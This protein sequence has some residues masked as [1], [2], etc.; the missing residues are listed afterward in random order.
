MAGR[1]LVEWSKGQGGIGDICNRVKNFFKVGRG[2]IPTGSLDTKMII[3]EY[4][5][6]L[7]GYNSDTL[8]EIDQLLERYDLPKFTRRN[9]KS[10]KA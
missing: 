8:D 9:R 5:N 2:V 4:Y 6:Q 7:S 10:G 3:K 1:G